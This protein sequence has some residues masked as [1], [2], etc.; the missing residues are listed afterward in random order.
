[1]RI[2]TRRG[3]NG[4]TRLFSGEEVWKDNP[5]LEA[6]GSLDE[7]NAWIGLLLSKL[8]WSDLRERLD[9]IQSDLHTIASELA[10]PMGDRNG[11]VELPPGRVEAL[12]QWIDEMSNHLPALR[13]FVRLGGSELAAWTHVARTVC[14]RAERRMAPLLRQEEMREEPF[15]YVNRLSDFLFVLARVV[16]ERSGVAERPWRPGAE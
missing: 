4:N 1:M 11:A 12:E 5:R 2:Y 9:R 6:L 15:R 3:D 8:P 7:L 10:T 13:S 14:R 16:N